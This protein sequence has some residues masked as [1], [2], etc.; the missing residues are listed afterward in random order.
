MNRN[1]TTIRVLSACVAFLIALGT[2]KTALADD[3]EIFIGTSTTGVA[4]NILFILDTSGS[5]DNEVKVPAPYD[6]SIEYSRPATI[7]CDRARVYFVPSGSPAPQNCSGLSSFPTTD[8]KCT[9]AVSALA[10]SAGFYTDSFIRWRRTGSRSPYTY[11]WGDTIGTSSTWYDVDCRGDYPASGPFP[12]TYSGSTNSDAVKYTNNSAATNSYWANAGTSTSY[13]LYS[14]NYLNYIAGGRVM[15]T[16]TRLSVMQQAA[17][18]LINSLSNVNVGIMRYSNNGGRNDAA[19]S[20]G[21]VA[22]PVVPVEAARA[23][24]IKTV[25]ELT[26]NGYTPLSETLYEAYRYYSG[27][28]VYF[29]DF[30][31]VSPF[32]S[33]DSSRVSA[34]SSQYKSPMEGSCQ[35]NFIVYLTDGLPTRDNEAD[36]LI[37]SLP[38]RPNRVGACDDTTV[39]PYNGRD[40]NGDPI[41]EGWNAQSGRCMAA[42][43]EYMFNSDLNTQYEG[44]Q[45]V[46]LYTIGFGGDPSLLAASD[47]LSAAARRGGGSFH[48]AGDLDA[49]QAALN[50][51]IA[52]IQQESVTFT[53]PTVA[54]NAFNRTRTLND[55]YVTVFQPGP[56]RHWDGNLKKYHLNPDDGSIRGQGGAPAVDANSGFFNQSAKSYWTV[57]AADGAVVTNGGAAS[58][59]PS[60]ETRKVYTYVGDARP[61]A[62]VNLAPTSGGEAYQV[63]R[64]NPLLTTTVMG[65]ATE[66]QL[67]F[68]IDFARGRDLK[69]VDGDPATDTRKRMGD[70]LHSQPGIVIYGGSPSDK[71]KDDA[72]VFVATN[73]GML[74]AIDARDDSGNELWSFI[75]QELL[76]HQFALYQNAPANPKRYGIDGNIKV[77]KYD[78]NSDGVVDPSDNDRVILYFG[79]GRGGR[80]Y[81]ALDVTHRDQP[82]F[83]WS[84]GP[85]SPGFE[86]IGQTWST[87]ELTRVRIDGEEQN[88]LQYVLVFG[89]GYDTA[90]EGTNFVAS[91]GTGNSL[92]MVDAVRGHLLWSASRSGAT[93]NLDKMTHSI[94]SDVTVLDLDGNGFADRMYVGDMAGQLWRFD[95]FSGDPKSTVVSGGVMASLGAAAETTP[96][97]ANTRR[98]YNAPDVAAVRRRGIDPFLNIAIGSGYRGHPLNETIQDRFYSI[99]D[100]DILTKYRQS[101]YNDATR[102]IITD[103]SARLIDVTDNPNTTIP[104]GAAGW[105]IRLQEDNGDWAGEKVLTSATTFNN[106]VLFTTYTPSVTAS[107]DPC[108]PALG[109]NQVC[110]VSVFDGSPVGD[111]GRC[112]RLS[113]GGIAPQISFLFPDPDDRDPPLP[114]DPPDPEGPNDPEGPGNG[115]PPGGPEPDKQGITCMSGVEVLGICRDFDSR[116]KTYWSE[117]N[118][119]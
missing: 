25:N 58:K 12:T 74:H 53:A 63:S 38:A 8:L 43:A 60:W 103:T 82:K 21:I 78:T 86:T 35:K 26:A 28:N 65:V 50:N 70:P 92:Y 117:S 110:A 24:L 36:T 52:E 61:G 13:T 112:S 1:T 19:A 32:K 51:I 6:P 87:P 31:T 105:K 45:N 41:P 40:R 101:Y 72:V 23:D 3:S 88:S 118:A 42:L 89:G 73:D 11:S 62:M 27:G 46:S 16:G 71:D 98:F 29:G 111:T 93:L 114:P 97:V 84:I 48:A 76:S 106:T 59:L 20:G 55:L 113:Q 7:G 109:Q 119:Q 56:R 79:L 102:A 85:D 17:R 9:Q 80:H 54:V 100:Y 77:L 49:L 67:G 44:Q 34:G 115:D 95:V 90:E 47:W 99:R 108:R 37:G 66:T 104:S 83:M 22:H 91:N 10:S 64:D 30:A 18:N 39:S 116:L 107:N 57:G 5:M 69:N 4:P 68:A 2:G 94:P 96:T 81:Y 14:G 33:V 15:E 75:P